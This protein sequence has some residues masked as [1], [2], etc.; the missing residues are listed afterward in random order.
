MVS[1]SLELSTSITYTP[2]TNFNSENIKEL[3]TILIGPLGEQAVIDFREIDLED[4]EFT[5]PSQLT[6]GA[7]I[8]KEKSW[9]LGAEYTNL[10]TS[11]LINRTFDINDVEYN[12]A[13]KFRLGGFIIP[14]Y[15]SF[16]SYWK[17]AVYR[18]GIRFEETGINI[19]GEDINEFGISF[20]VGLP[21]GR[22]FSNVNL[23][24]ELGKRGTKN[25]GL[26]LENF[27]N[28]FISLSLNDKWFEKR[29]YE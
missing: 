28:T 1:E 23:G 9:F 20:G 24:F 2:E 26:V 27:F 21:V 16:G 22:L 7:G 14:D 12:D 25:Q 3:S 18:A 10:K 11:N 8:G 4:T 6:I 29:Y 5:F 19:R 13:S 17:R 15:K